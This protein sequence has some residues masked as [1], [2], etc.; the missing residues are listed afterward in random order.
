ME[1]SGLEAEGLHLQCDILQQWVSVLLTSGKTWEEFKNSHAFPYL[2]RL[3]QKCW[4]LASVVFKALRRFQY[5]TQAENHYSQVL[6]SMFVIQP[7]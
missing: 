4:G 3:S 7:C 1:P 5:E 6:S 2:T